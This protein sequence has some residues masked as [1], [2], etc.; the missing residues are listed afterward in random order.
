[1]EKLDASY[2]TE[3]YHREQTGWDTKGITTPLKDY[4]DQL[5][6]RS[7]RILIPGA[8]NAYEAGYLWQQGFEN[9]YVLDWAAPPLQRFGETYPDF[10][11]DQ[12]LK[13]DFF[14]LNGQ[15][16][17]IVEQTFF[18]AFEPVLRPQYAEKAAELLNR[19]GKLVGLLWDGDFAGGPPFGGTPDEYKKLFA[20][21]F[22]I[23]VMA[24][25]YNSIKPRA[26]REVFVK[27]IKK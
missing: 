25:A 12:L 6:D 1:M 7:L 23:D 5:E 9:V 19:G 13:D 4:F 10:P 2:W 24:S 3:R 27:L 26:G 15:F 21:H 20:D 18:C 8:G 14:Q 11:R 16:D 22:K 17:L